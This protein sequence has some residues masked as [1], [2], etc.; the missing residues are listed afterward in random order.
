MNRTHMQTVVSH[1]QAYISNQNTTSK[2]ANTQAYIYWTRRVEFARCVV[3]KTNLKRGS[4]FDA[5]MEYRLK[6]QKPV[7]DAVEQHYNSQA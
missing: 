6:K 7:C 1:H 3:V 5:A 2:E 4:P